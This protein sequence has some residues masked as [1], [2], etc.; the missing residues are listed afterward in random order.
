MV[1]DRRDRGQLLL[2]GAVAIAFIILGV[3]VVFNG[4]LYTQTISA[5]DSVEQVDDVSTAERE[6]ASGIQ[7]VVQRTNVNE[8]AD[9][10]ASVLTYVGDYRNAS[11]DSRPVI[12]NVSEVSKNESANATRADLQNATVFD[13]SDRNSSEVGHFALEVDPGSDRVNVSVNETDGPETNLTI[14]PNEDE[15][16][17]VLSGDGID[18]T[19]DSDRTVRVD[20]VSGAINAS[21]NCSPEDLRLV[22]PDAEYD[23]IELESDGDSEGQYELVARGEDGLTG[24]NG[25]PDGH[26]AVWSVDISYTYDSSDVTYERELTVPIYGDRP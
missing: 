7:G 3:V 23:D 12:S 11:A 17:F 25:V 10:E 2:V 1:G 24:D 16:E 13:S 8:S 18:C 14:E 9:W 6:L 20:L 5:G 19:V 21:G 22:D 26:S 15:D 4:V